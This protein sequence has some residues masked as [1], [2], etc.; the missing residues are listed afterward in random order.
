MAKVSRSIWRNL[1]AERGETL[2]QAM[3]RPSPFP[4]R[5][6]RH[7]SYQRNWYLNAT[8]RLQQTA[9]AA[10]VLRRNTQGISA[11]CQV[12]RH[13]EHQLGGLVCEDRLVVQLLRQAYAVLEI[14]AYLLGI[15]HHLQLAV[16][17][18][19]DSRNSLPV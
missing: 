2:V 1:R 19:M 11:F 9:T 18:A 13:E 15:A 3:A 12:V 4:A 16:V 17:W 14:N 8:R 5:D 6:F 7:A 10:G